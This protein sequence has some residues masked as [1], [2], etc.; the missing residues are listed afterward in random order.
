MGQ[1]SRNCSAHP[2][3]AA[4]WLCEGCDRALCPDCVAE[5]PAGVTSFT[6][7]CHCEGIAAQA[8]V[9]RSHWSLGAR[10]RGAWRYPFQSSTA[11]ALFATA[12]GS[13]LSQW[14]FSNSPFFLKPVTFSIFVGI[15]AACVSAIVKSSALGENE[16]AAPDFTDVFSDL[17][18]P[19]VRAVLATACLWGPAVAYGA[20]REGPL[21]SLAGDPVLYLLLLGGLLYFPIAVTMAAVDSPWTSLLFPVRG[22]ACI[23]RLG[24]DY[25][26]TVGFIA[27]V[28]AAG[29]AAKSLW[30]VAGEL[31]LV[32]PSVHRVIS[33]MML[34]IC[35]RGLGLL[36]HVRGD[37]VD[38][39]VESDFWVPLLP[40]VKPRGRLQAAPVEATSRRSRAPL[41]LTDFEAPQ[42]P[43]VLVGNALATSSLAEALA[44]HRRLPVE[45]WSELSAGSHVA[46]AQKSAADG[47]L[48]Y[49]VQALQHVA[50]KSADDAEAPK[51]CILL[52]RIYGER[53]SDG[54]SAKKV[55]EHVLRRYPGSNA[56]TFAASRVQG[57]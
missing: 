57:T 21:S 45:R 9:H 41:S 32:S 13:L 37:S 48:S 46:V 27:L 14:V 25:W 33:L 44:Q 51:A 50:R 1:V 34:F 4:G 43:A 29:V 22:F 28:V 40:G 54:A 52:A 8:K 36:L 10:L 49:A 23:T 55:Y 12:V 56:A 39:G 18:R 38:Y 53:L 24:G 16:F 11:V 2:K 20:L 31:P 30:S 7:C 3:E 17:V 15:H 19:S 5:R 35:A 47:D 6:V 42:D 26:R